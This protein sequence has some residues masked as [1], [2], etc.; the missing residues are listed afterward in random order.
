MYMT[1]N[2]LYLPCLIMILGMTCFT[3]AQCSAVESDSDEE[4]QITMNEM[5]KQCE[6]LAS[7]QQ[8]MTADIKKQ[9][10]TLVKQVA[11]MNNASDDQKLEQIARTLTMMSQQ[12]INMDA[13]KAMLRD[14]MMEHMAK[15][16]KIGPKSAST[17]PA[18]GT[19]SF[20]KKVK[21]VKM[22]SRKS[23]TQE[24]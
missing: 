17:C 21:E 8:E 5:S 12:R 15:H 23:N 18:C 2:I 1:T 13:Q 19:S 16:M 10:E 14:D 22:K 24:E 11:D 7:R 4:N 3:A 6:E 9:N 20:D